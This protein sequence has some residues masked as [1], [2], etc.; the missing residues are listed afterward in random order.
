MFCLFTH[1][2]KL[3][4]SNSDSGDTDVDDLKAIFFKSK[5]TTHHLKMV[6]TSEHFANDEVTQ[7][8]LSTALHDVKGDG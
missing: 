1:Q 3:I 7:I 2:T 8:Y 6:W 4:Y 5:T